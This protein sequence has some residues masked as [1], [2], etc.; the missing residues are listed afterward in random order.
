MDRKAT[1]IWSGSIKNG[2]GKI[3]TESG[4]LKNANYSFTTRFESAPGTNPEELI[5]AAHSACF[6]M[7]TSAGLSMAGFEPT[8][9]EVTA[10]VTVGKKGEGWEIGSSKLKLSAEVPGIDEAKFQQLV[11][12]AKANCPVSK[13][14][15][16]EIS[17][18]ARLETG[19]TK[20]E[21]GF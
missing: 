21:L 9:L 1:S 3:S 2:S 8:R 4:V 18:E 7:A 15:R 16:A 17:L 12:D 10:T 6:A 19:K 20:P 5:A 13:L 14:L 11:A